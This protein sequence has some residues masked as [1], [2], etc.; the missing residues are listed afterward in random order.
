MCTAREHEISSDILMALMRH[1]RLAKEGTCTSRP[2]ESCIT[3][4]RERVTRFV[5]RGVAVDFAL[6]AFPGK[7]PNRS[8]VIG[9]SPDM[10]EQLWLNF[11]RKIYDQIQEIYA[12]GVRITIC[13]DG[14]VFSDLVHIADSQRIPTLRYLEPVSENIGYV[15]LRRT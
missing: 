8:K 13:S 10:A 15:T 6:P 14:N 9:V 2:C 11:L 1:Q 12:P 4:H 5:S 7:S 3:A